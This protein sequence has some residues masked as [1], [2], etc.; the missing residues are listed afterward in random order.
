MRFRGKRLRLES[1]RYSQSQLLSR[2]RP[3]SPNQARGAKVL[4]LLCSC[5]FLGREICC[6]QRISYLETSAVAKKVAVVLLDGPK[7]KRSSAFTV[8]LFERSGAKKERRSCG[9]K[10]KMR[11]DEMQQQMVAA[12]LVV[13]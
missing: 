10:V 6:L 1:D 4:D 7:P 12:A 3:C 13:K 11:C 9:R 2:A 5:G 8:V